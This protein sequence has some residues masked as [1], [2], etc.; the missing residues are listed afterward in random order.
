MNLDSYQLLLE[1]GSY[2]KLNHGAPE[3]R[4]FQ[5]QRPEYSLNCAF[6]GSAQG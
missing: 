1:K 4:V 5:E 2:T 3:E 6:T